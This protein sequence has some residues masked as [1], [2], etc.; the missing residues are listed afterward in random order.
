MVYAGLLSGV[1]Y[2]FLRLL[3]RIFH[4]GRLLTAALDLLFWVSALI[5]CT[6]VLLSVSHE[7]L[8]LYT[9][10][11][12]ASGVTLYLSGVSVVLW[13]FA[14]VVGKGLK[15]LSSKRGERATLKKKEKLQTKNN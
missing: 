14:E 11:G 6:L 3:R 5:L 9:L 1:C 12:I 4:A 2:D 10:L 13:Q 8:R 15:K 7:G